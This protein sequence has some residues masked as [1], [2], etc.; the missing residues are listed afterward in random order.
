MKTTV[1]F[2][3]FDITEYSLSYEWMK[4][5]RAQL[6]NHSILESINFIEHPAIYTLGA[7]ATKENILISSNALK[8]LNIKKIKVD[9]GGDVTC[10][11]IGQVV[12]YPILNLKNR[13]IKPVEYVRM[14]E[15][16]ILSTL[17][18]F[19]ISGIRINGSPGIWVGSQKIA[20]IGIS[21][22]QGITTHGFS[23]NVNND[24]S[25]FDYINACGIKNLEVISI[26]KIENKS[27]DISKIKKIIADEFV[28]RLDIKDTGMHKI[29]L[30]KT[31]IRSI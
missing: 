1:D 4:N 16:I 13:G 22:K 29:K 8:A 10:H 27:I 20:A 12:V 28:S 24:L 21:I 9:R 30:E 18:K 2:N 26:K 11:S 25:L 7:N 3:D 23:I 19:N 6:V 17:T 5:N 15:E 31:L 14:L